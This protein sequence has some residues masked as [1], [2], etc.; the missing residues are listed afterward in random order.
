MI[1]ATNTIGFALGLVAAIWLFFEWV[2][3]KSFWG[4]LFLFLS[5]L[6]VGIETIFCMCGY[7]HALHNI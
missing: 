7:I 6:I 4:F 5:I 2:E 3:I 1:F